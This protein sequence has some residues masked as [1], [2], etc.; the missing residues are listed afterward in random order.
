LADFNDVEGREKRLL[1]QDLD[2]FIFAA[3]AL[4]VVAAG[5]S[6]PGVLPNPKYPDHYDD[7]QWAL[8]PWACGFN[9]LVCGAYVSR[10][11]PGALVPT[12][13]WP[14]PFSRIGPGLC[15]SP[16][17]SFSAEGGNTDS[18]YRNPPGLGVW[19]ISGGG[20]A[21]DRIGTSFAAPLLARA[22]AFTIDQLQRHWCAPGTQPFAITARAFLTL[23]AAPPAQDADI[24]T[25]VE[26]TLGYGRASD[27]R[28]RAPSS[29][30]AVMLW[31]G[32][33]DSPADIVRVQLPIPQSWLN[34]AD[35]PILH[36][37]VCSDPP[38]NEAA[39][40]TWACR[41]VRPVLH[42]RPDTPGIRAPHGGYA[43]YPVI[44]RRYKLSPYKKGEE[45]AADGD[46][47]LLEFSYEEVAPYTAAMDF[48]PR[49][50]VAFAAEIFDGS[51]NPIDPQPA[52]QSLPI[53]ATM[54]RLS[55]QPTPL[56]SPIIV[57]SRVS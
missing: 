47:W 16:V 21:E 39:P 13:G 33:I 3:D 53:A 34:E 24:S 43:S 32:Y 8:G 18:T 6:A 1:L 45:K 28:L 25:L 15:D 22:A 55:T 14:S 29:G 48:D 30:S 38:V 42:L 44:D 5:N 9:T 41:R 36:L 52:M 17:P 23:T 2:N 7:P 31:Q 19:G 40:H 54:T 56:R 50:R 57:K 51:E 20:L 46:V 49:Q 26:R 10:V 27:A 12:V 37:V 11:S 35:E 4:V